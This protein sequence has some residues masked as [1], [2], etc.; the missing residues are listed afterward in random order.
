MYSEGE[1]ITSDCIEIPEE[2][3]IEELR[4]GKLIH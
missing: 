4:R 2:Y 1:H 3:L